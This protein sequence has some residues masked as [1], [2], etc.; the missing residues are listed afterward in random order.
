MFKTQSKVLQDFIH[1]IKVCKFIRLCYLQGINK[2][3]EV[4]CIHLLNY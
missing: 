1:K 2:S 4:F 3:D